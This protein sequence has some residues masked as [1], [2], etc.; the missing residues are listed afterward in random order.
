MFM[1]EI[2]NRV[3]FVNGKHPRIRLFPIVISKRMLP[4]LSFSDRWSRGTKLW[5][6]DWVVSQIVY[7]GY[8]GPDPDPKQ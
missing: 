3:V 4:E 2:S 8:L 6:R 5:E 7:G 1:P